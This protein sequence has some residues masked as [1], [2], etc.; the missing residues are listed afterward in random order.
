MRSDAEQLENLATAQMMMLLGLNR[1]CGGELVDRYLYE[2]EHPGNLNERYFKYR[3]EREK[4]RDDE[5]YV[6]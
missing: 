6:R 2:N 1:V 4:Q 3:A 5:K